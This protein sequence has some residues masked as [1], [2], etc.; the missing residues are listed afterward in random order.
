MLSW[1]QAARYVRKL[2]RSQIISGSLAPGSLAQRFVR[3]E[4]G[5][6]APASYLI[7]VILALII[8]F[9]TFDLG[10]RKGARLAVE[11]A[12]YCGARA[13]ATQLPVTEK[14]GAC[15]SAEEKKAIATATHACLAAVVSKRGTLGIGLPGTGAFATLID[16]ASSQTQ[17]RILGPSGELNVDDCVGHNDEVTV[18]V[19]FEHKIPVPLSPFFW[20]SDGH[21]VMVA[22]AST[23]LHTVK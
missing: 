14:E 17:L 2:R 3:D 19:T 21:T 20:G 9:F 5:E 1:H 6:L 18:E 4:R 12:A 10:L 7:G 22:Q 16:R 23:M 13:A 15:L 11:Y 8:I